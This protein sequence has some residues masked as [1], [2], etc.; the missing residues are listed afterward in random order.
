MFVDPTPLVRVVHVIPS[1]DVAIFPAAPTITNNDSRGDQAALVINVDPNPLVR[2]VHVAT[3][4]VKELLT[5]VDVVPIV[6]SVGLVMLIASVAE[7]T[8]RIF[9]VVLAAVAAAEYVR[10]GP[11]PAGEFVGLAPVQAS[12]PAAVS[13]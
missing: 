5:M 4:A 8:R 1:G 7:F 11:V 10:K 9:L 12:L 2:L 3:G 6:A 13:K